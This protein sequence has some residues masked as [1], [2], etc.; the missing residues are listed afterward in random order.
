MT[1]V[2]KVVLHFPHNLVDQP[3]I[4][5]L[6]KDYDLQFNI[7]K[8]SVTPKEEGILVLELSGKKQNYKEAIRFLNQSGVE[9]QLLIQDVYRNND[10][11]THCGVCVTMCPVEAFTVD[12]TTR[13]VEFHSTE[14]IA[15][16]LCTRTC[17]VRAMEIR[18]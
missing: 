6:V 15:C 11:C 9:L 4:Y 10:K 5:K 14:C 8:A 13:K 16:E 17:P 2:R 7:L 12:P 1:V 18:L 3:I